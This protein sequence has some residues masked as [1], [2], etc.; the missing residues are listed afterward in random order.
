MYKEK[1]SVKQIQTSVTLTNPSAPALALVVPRQ[2]N[3]E[4]TLQTN[5]V[6]RLEKSNVLIAL[7]ENEHLGKTAEYCERL[8]KT[9]SSCVT[10]SIPESGGSSTLKQKVYQRM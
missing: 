4:S 10:F 8:S 6:L 9:T 3:A 1:K 2:M 7:P 5:V